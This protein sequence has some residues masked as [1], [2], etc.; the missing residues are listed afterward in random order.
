VESSIITTVFLP[1]A[2]GV[3]M[4][5][6]G[7]SLTI[8]D[9]KRVVI[10]PRAVVVGLV[11]QMLLLPFVAYGIAVGFGLPPKLAVGLM[12]LAASPGGA[13][14]NLFSHLARGD[15]AL[16]ITLTA[17]NSV[18]SLFTLPLIVNFALSAFMADDRTIPLQFDKVVQVFAI[19]LVPVGIGMI[20]RWQKPSLADRLDKPV[21]IISAV[22]LFLVIAAAV[23]KER[24]ELLEN[25]QRVGLAC[26]VFNL[27]S[28]A[29][30]FVVP[31]LARVQRR[32]ATAIAM[33]IGV[34]NGT[35]AIAIASSPLLLNDAAMA[36]PAAIYSLIM[37]FTAAG[38][39]WFMARRQ[40][41]A[42]AAIAGKREPPS[43]APKAAESK[44]RGSKKKKKKS[45]APK[46]DAPSAG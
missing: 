7:L 34:H 5:G 28:M 19:V 12:L 16:N 3:I 29:V 40:G 23:V 43:A 46:N 4:L 33:E 8:A 22:F 36:I 32:Q 9:F 39:G 10:Y 37:F 14:A 6:L 18:L 1:I 27:V 11:C 41:A 25:F 45:S 42:E 15:V 30:G 2:L 38:F 21:R 17:L 31:L 35:L 20:V 13:T 44:D 26:L 24:A